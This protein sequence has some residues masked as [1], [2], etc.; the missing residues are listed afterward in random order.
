MLDIFNS[1]NST[2]VATVGD[3]VPPSGVPDV[4]DVDIAVRADSVTDYREYPCA[5]SNFWQHVAVTV[6]AHILIIAAIWM[7]RQSLVFLWNLLHLVVWLRPLLDGV[8]TFI[9]I[10][11]C[12]GRCALDCT[13][14]LLGCCLQVGRLCGWIEA[15]ADDGGDDQR[16]AGVPLGRGDVPDVRAHQGA[17]GGGHVEGVG[18]DGVDLMGGKVAAGGG[19]GGSGAC[20]SAATTGGHVEELGGVPAD[21]V[22]DSL[23]SR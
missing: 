10:L 20:S 23:K 16:G 11:T 14:C 1:A 22:E 13:A 17:G 3:P 12:C 9:Q 2:S 7:L 6:A 4:S 18:V 5:S 8:K 15:A 19:A 21:K